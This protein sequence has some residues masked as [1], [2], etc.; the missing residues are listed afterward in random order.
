MKTEATETRTP[1]QIIFIGT[2]GTGKT[3]ALKKMVLAELKKKNSHVLVVVPDD[4]EW[5]SVP[6]VHSDFPERISHYVGIR[7]IIY[8]PGLLEIISNNFRE[9]LLIFDDCRSYFTTTTDPT[10]L[11]ILIRRRQKMLDVAVVG[12]GFT[13]IPPA[14][15]TFATH[16]VLF[17]TIDNIER[18]KNVIQNFDEMKAAQLRINEK[19]ATDAHYN[20]IIKL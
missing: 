2:N 6:F 20:E 12:H 17:K 9:G 15:F 7:K 10:L 8:F 16:Y 13:Q 19:S 3:T 5:N 18:R 11:N 4:M 14:F 1:K